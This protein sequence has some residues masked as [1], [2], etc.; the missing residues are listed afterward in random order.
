MIV[1]ASF[2]NVARNSKWL[3]PLKLSPVY[4]AFNIIID[5]DDVEKSVLS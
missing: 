4:S 3:D 2:N 1:F 5:E